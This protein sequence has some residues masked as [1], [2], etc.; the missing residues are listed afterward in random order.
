MAEVKR[1]PQER[2]ITTKPPAR[3]RLAR[4][5][6]KLI[7]AITILLFV[8]IY[9]LVAM[10]VVQAPVFDSFAKPVQTLI[11]LV[12]GMAWILPLMPLIKWM[13][14]PDESQAG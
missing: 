4:K 14:R 5:S 9:A 12:V 2:Q 6:R 7:G 8:V 10:V 1:P 3:K 13:E 11:F